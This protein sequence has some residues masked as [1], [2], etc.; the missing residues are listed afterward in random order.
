MTTEHI[1]VSVGLGVPALIWCIATFLVT[2][3][4]TTE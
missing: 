2:R 4:L 3:K 1:I